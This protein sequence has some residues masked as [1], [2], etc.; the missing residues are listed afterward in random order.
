MLAMLKKLNY[1]YPY[2]QAIGFYLQRAGNYR[3]AQIQL[4][5]KFDFKYDFYLDHGMRNLEYSKEWK[6]YY[7]KGF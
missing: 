1:T 3:E 2:H 5:K 4:L 7:P 6:L